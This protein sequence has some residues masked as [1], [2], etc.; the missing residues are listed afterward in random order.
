MDGQKCPHLCPP[1]QAVVARCHN[2]T[3]LMS[4]A[5]AVCILSQLTLLPSLSPTYVLCLSF[6]AAAVSVLANCC[7]L[8]SSAQTILH[9]GISPA[10]CPPLTAQVKVLAVFYKGG[11]WAQ[12]EPRL[13]GT[14]ENQLGIREWLESQGHTYVVTDDKEGANSTLDKEIVDAEIVITT[15]FHPGYINRERIEKAKK[16]KA[17]IT[18]GVGNCPPN[19]IGLL[20][21]R[22]RPR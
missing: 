6:S 19:P 20:T 21:A 10:V 16:L 7:S 22:I 4:A 1:S 15:P 5:H 13:L 11:K 3:A 17:C 2:K 12:Q 8:L 18:A 9:N 14:V